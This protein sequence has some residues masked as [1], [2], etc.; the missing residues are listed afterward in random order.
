MSASVTVITS[1]RSCEAY[2]ASAVRS[3]LEQSLPDLSLVVVD[4]ASPSDAWLEA[5]RPFRGDPRLTAYRASRNVGRYRISNRVFQESDSPFV[6][7]QDADDVSSRERLAEQVR[8]LERRRLDIVGTGFVQID[9]AGREQ[10]RRRMPRWPLFRSVLG[11]D[12]V[13]HPATMVCRRAAFDRLGGFDGTARLEADTDFLVRAQFT[14]RIGN[15]PRPLYFYRRRPR[16]L[17]AAPDTA[18]GSPA[19]EAYRRKMFDRAEI[20][21]HTADREALL[22]ASRA[23]E[24][25]MDFRLEKVAV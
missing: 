17:T 10:V 18:L 16:S 22:E 6:A 1:H 4:D 21:R 5:L 7:F 13:I 8:A 11:R 12:F 3:I 24:N 20:L 2:L 14:C 23:P 25:D 9:E 15:V 19:R